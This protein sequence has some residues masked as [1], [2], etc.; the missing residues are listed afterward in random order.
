MYFTNPF[1][2]LQPSDYGLNNAEDI[3][4]LIGYNGRN[5]N[6]SQNTNLHLSEWN[7]TVYN[8][9]LSKS[10]PLNFFNIITATENLGIVD[11]TGQ[12]PL[13]FSLTAGGVTTSASRSFTLNFDKAPEITGFSVSSENNINL[14]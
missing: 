6:L 14:I 7:S 11:Y 12:Y 5:Y 10:I 2:S 4:I 9:Y 1:A 3:E 8:G 13:T